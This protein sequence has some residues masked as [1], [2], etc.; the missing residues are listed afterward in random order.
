MGFEKSDVRE[1]VNDA[2]AAVCDGVRYLGDLSYAIFPKDVAHSLGELNKSFLNVIRTCVDKD[3]E[4]IDER[5][6][7][8][9]RLRE[10]WK[11][12]YAYDKSEESGAPVN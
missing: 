8:G 1:C 2:A 12:R 7:G 6:A 11:Q 4:W 5:V 10:R 3:I 9:D